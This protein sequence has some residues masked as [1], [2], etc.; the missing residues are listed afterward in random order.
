MKYTTNRRYPY[1]QDA[2]DAGHGGLHSELL[3][4]AVDDDLVALNAA[5]AASLIRD[6]LIAE[7]RLGDS[8]PIA[9]ASEVPVFCDTVTSLTGTS[10]RSD[11]AEVRVTAPGWLKITGHIRAK[12]T[13][14]IT[15]SARHQV[16]LQHYRTN[17]VSGGL[18]LL[19]T[20]VSTAFQS[21][22]LDVFNS[23]TGVFEVRT[24]DQVWMS[25]SHQNTGSSVVVVGTG[26]FGTRLEAT[27]YG[28]L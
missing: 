12:A 9:A 14:T 7:L 11:P 25:F 8:S 21:G 24:T 4:R 26:T 16:T 20:R 15:A 3:A 18:L 17:P 28:G 10:I 6:S 5:V 22:T 27:R 13:G 2:K 1:P 19:A 23:V